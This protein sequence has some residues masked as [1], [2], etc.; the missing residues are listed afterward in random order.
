MKETQNNKSNRIKNF[1]LL[2]IIFFNYECYFF[3]FIKKTHFFARNLKI[4]PFLESFSFGFF[5][6]LF[7]FFSLI[8]SL[9]LKANRAQTD[10][11]A[12]QTLFYIKVNF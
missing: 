11:L 3:V 12:N 10:E 7:L 2:K 6:L 1:V 4:F 5:R 9:S 8:L